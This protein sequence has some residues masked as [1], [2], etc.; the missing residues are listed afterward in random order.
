MRLLHSGC[1]SKDSK[2]C[3]TSGV[4]VQPLSPR[5]SNRLLRLCR[6]S[7]WTCTSQYLWQVSCR[8]LPLF[9]IL[10]SILYISAVLV[11]KPLFHQ[12]CHSLTLLG[13]NS[14]GNAG[15]YPQV[16]SHN[17]HL[18]ELT[19]CV[20]LLSG[21][22]IQCCL[23]LYAWKYMATYILSSFKT[24]FGKCTNLALVTLLG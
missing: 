21:I 5:G 7:S 23:L 10:N 15:K 9:P 16:E 17:D 3:I 18:G 13:L 14:H 1:N 22:T 4:T 19:S 8:F 2:Y 20:F 11:P 6:A 12:S 24:G